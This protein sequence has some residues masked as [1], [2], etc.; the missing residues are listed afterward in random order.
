[1]EKR[2]KIKLLTIIENAMYL[3][4]STFAG[5]NLKIAI[6]NTVHTMGTIDGRILITATV[7]GIVYRHS[8]TL[9]ACLIATSVCEKKHGPFR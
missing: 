4:H 9:L 5:L 3:L 1:M 7:A 2:L 6:I 8:S